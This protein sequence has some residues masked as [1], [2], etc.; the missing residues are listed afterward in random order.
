LLDCMMDTQLLHQE[1]C[2]RVQIRIEQSE[3]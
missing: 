3:L 2:R 1:Y